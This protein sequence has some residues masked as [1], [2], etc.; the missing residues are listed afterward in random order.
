MGEISTRGAHVH[1]RH[2]EG[3]SG[4]DV[5]RALGM[6]WRR[7]LR[8]CVCWKSFPSKQATTR[9][10]ELLNSEAPPR[11]PKN[12]RQQ[13]KGNRFLAGEIE[14]LGGARAPFIP[15]AKTRRPPNHIHSSH[16]C[17]PGCHLPRFFQRAAFSSFGFL[18]PSSCPYSH[19]KWSKTKTNDFDIL[20]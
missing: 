19:T 3:G 14:F 7:D 20:A 11:A 9:S 16:L 18:P 6:S 15:T 8:N 17:T 1:G 4:M 2:P 10:L 5:A 12:R 13:R